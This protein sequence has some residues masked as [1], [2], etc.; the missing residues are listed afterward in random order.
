ML[1]VLIVEDNQANL[2]L[3]QIYFSQFGESETAC[4]GETALKK[5]F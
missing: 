4:D 3:L 1:K 5:Y 2:K